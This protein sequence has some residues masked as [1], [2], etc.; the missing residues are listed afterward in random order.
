[1]IATAT[2]IGRTHRLMQQ[3]CQDFAVGSN[4]QDSTAF[5]L[6]FDGCGSKYRDVSGIH[7]SHNEVGANLVGIYAAQFIRKELTVNSQQRTINGQCFLEDVVERLY[8]ACVT[9]L[10][11]FVTLH[12]F[13]DEKA[14]RHFIAT[15][16]LCT[17]V[18]FV[19]IAETA[20]FFWSGDGYIG[21][22]DHFI[23][24]ESNNQPDYLAYQLLRE[25]QNGRFNTFTVHTQ[26]TI[27]RLLVATD[28]WSSTQL[29]QL[30]KPKH[31]LSLQRWI[32]VQSR[33]RGVFEDD[34]AIAIYTHGN[35]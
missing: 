22:N 20:V 34:G 10:D 24:L 5:G 32:N 14:R 33:E 29:Q 31:S 25:E 1:M 30:G 7:Q 18:G 2:I 17:V 11:C 15:R 13:H 12:P 3:N 19:K 28:G 26:E 9:Y 4:L 23:Q 16:L 27:D 6:V 8:Q 21:I 35:T